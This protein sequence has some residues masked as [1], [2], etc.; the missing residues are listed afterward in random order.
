MLRLARLLV[1]RSRIWNQWISAN[2]EI[3]SKSPSESN[4]DTK[5]TS[6]HRTRRDISVTAISQSNSIRVGKLLPNL[7]QD[8]LMPATTCLRHGRDQSCPF[9]DILT[10]AQQILLTPRHATAS[11]HAS[12]EGTRRVERLV[13][14]CRPL[15]SCLRE[16]PAPCTPGGTPAATECRLLAAIAPRWFLVA[17]LAG[18]ALGLVFVIVEC[19]GVGF[20]RM[21]CHGTS[22]ACYRRHLERMM[23][24][25]LAVMMLLICC[26]A[27]LSGS[28]FAGFA[29]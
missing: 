23:L 19:L 26:G 4:K 9:L 20:E 7:Y 24:L 14:Q 6:T 8:H 18:L 25:S 22:P 27:G 12:S 13:S 11:P 5:T 17:V 1:G 10:D 15:P 28:Q 21:F 2:R 16:R 29:L 3:S